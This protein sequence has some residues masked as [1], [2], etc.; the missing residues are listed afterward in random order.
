MVVKKLIGSGDLSMSISIINKSLR[1]AFLLL[2]LVATSCKTTDDNEELDII[3]CVNKNLFDFKIDSLV[4]YSAEDLVLVYENKQIKS[5]F[6]FRF[7]EENLDRQKNEGTRFNSI[8]YIQVSENVIKVKY[9]LI[10]W[11]GECLG[12]SN[13]VCID[14][15]H[16]NDNRIFKIE[17]SVVNQE[18]ADSIMISHQIDFFDWAELNDHKIHNSNGSINEDIFFSSLKTYCDQ[19]SD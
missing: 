15:Y 5:P 7:L 18:I 6:V 13:Y 14:S 1:I 8:E 3:E 4:K 17:Q 9:D 19:K 11:V 16:L 10:N 2:L 12:N